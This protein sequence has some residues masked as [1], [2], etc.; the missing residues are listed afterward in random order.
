S[1]ARIAD[2]ATRVRVVG[3]PAV[4][5]RLSRLEV[6]THDGLNLTAGVSAPAG[7]PSLAEICEF[8]RALAP[9]I[10]VPAAIMDRIANEICSLND[11]RTLKPLLA[12]IAAAHAPTER[13][14]RP[15]FPG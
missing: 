3:D 6:V 7:Q 12:A 10:G 14:S 4:A 8:A 11:A 9:E 5:A 1:D 15:A 2:L 13:A